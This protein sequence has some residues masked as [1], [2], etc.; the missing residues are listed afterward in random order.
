MT[1]TCNKIVILGAGALGRVV[2]DLIISQ[3]S[4][5]YFA[6]D[7]CTLIGNNLMGCQVIAINELVRLD[8]NIYQFLIAAL[9]PEVR[10]NFADRI[11]MGHFLFYKF[12]SEQS[13]ISPSS[14]IGSGCTIF[15]QTFVMNSAIIGNFV[16]VHFHCAIGHDTTIGDYCSIAPNCV[17]GGYSIIGEGTTLGMGVKVIPNRSIGKSCIIGAGSV[18]TKDIPDHC[19]AFGNPAK[20]I[21]NST[22][23]LGRNSIAI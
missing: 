8:P 4:V 3:I 13:V 16:H 19:I 14:E 18:V 6:D 21:K 15:P 12:I 20:I 10:K 2:Y 9:K 17:I 7:S 5:E 1:G 22:N 11:A 23:K